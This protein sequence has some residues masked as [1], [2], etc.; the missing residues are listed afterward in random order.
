MSRHFGAVLLGVGDA[1]LPRHEVGNSVDDGVARL[2]VGGD[3]LLVKGEGG[4]GLLDGLA[5]SLG[6]VPALLGEDGLADG[7]GDAGQGPPSRQNQAQDCHHLTIS[8]KIIQ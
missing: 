6:L 5:D 1:L 2:V 4:H 3:A 8:R 7:G